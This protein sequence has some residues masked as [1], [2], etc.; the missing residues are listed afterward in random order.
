MTSDH[1]QRPLAII[2]A[3][4]GSKRFPRK[5]IALL[6]GKPLIA[7]AI[8][9]ALKSNVFDLVCVSSEDDEIL[10]LAEK[11]GAQLALK[12]PIELSDDWTPLK[13]VCEYLLRHFKEKGKEY[14][15]FGLLLTTN[16]LRTSQDLKNAYKIFKAKDANFCMSL[17]E[18]AHPPQR[19]VW[20]Q[21]GLVQP[22]F[23]SQH[24]AQVQLLEPLYRHDGTIIFGKTK[25]FFET[26][27]FY[28]EKVVPYIIPAERSVDIDNPLDLAWA[29]FLMSKSKTA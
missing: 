26:G 13:K 10:R 11:H 5:N 6:A 4:G 19:A 9:A 20:I 29:E 28:S 17:V 23:G 12:R 27:E 16:P 14:S 25:A 24:M 3:R 7:Y 22:Y 8:E 21:S 18:Y 2:P 1:P 15:E